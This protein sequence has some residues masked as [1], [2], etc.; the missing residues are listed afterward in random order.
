MKI[1][2]SIGVLT[3][4][5]AITQSLTATGHST[6]IHLISAKTLSGDLIYPIGKLFQEIMIEAAVRVEMAID[7]QKMMGPNIS[8]VDF[9]PE[10]G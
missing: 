7:V 6:C 4:E 5:A 10:A 3:V 8:N 2:T 9:G 1:S